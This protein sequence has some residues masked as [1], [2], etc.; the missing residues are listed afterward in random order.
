MSPLYGLS[1]RIVSFTT[2]SSSFKFPDDFLWGSGTAAH[3]IEGYNV[4]SKFW[5]LKRKGGIWSQW[6]VE[7]PSGKGCNH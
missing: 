2:S 1:I 4:H 7:E 5:Q 3:Q 6:D